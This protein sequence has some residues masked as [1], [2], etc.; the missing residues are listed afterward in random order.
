M[1]PPAQLIPVAAVRFTWSDETTMSCSI[2][3]LKHLFQL[4]SEG[5]S[6]IEDGPSAAAPAPAEPLPAP[7]GSLRSQSEQLAILAQQSVES[8]LML[9]A[10]YS[11]HSSQK[12]SGRKVYAKVKLWQCEFKLSWVMKTV[13]GKYPNFRCS[14]P[15]KLRFS[16]KSTTKV[17]FKLIQEISFE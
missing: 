17:T 11:S 12:K 16:D 9:L 7:A 10:E 13:D 1:L 14:V 5:L 6:M 2:D 8:A 3:V 15:Q 4:Q